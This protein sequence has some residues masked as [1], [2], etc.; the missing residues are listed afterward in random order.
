MRGR[1]ASLPT[2]AAIAQCVAINAQQSHTAAPHQFRI[3]ATVTD[4]DHR[5][6]PNLTAAD[7]ELRDDGQRRLMT[8]VDATR[9]PL[10]VTLIVDRSDSLS[11]GPTGVRASA[12]RLIRDLPPG[13]EARV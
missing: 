6:V 11:L 13:D 10:S 4:R 9:R 5:S 7:F 3:V 1:L 12:M 8:R 2:F